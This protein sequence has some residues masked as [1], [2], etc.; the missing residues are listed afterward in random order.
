MKYAIATNGQMVILTEDDKV[1]HLPEASI[2]ASLI[3]NPDD[4]VHIP[5]NKDPESSPHPPEP[6]AEFDLIVRSGDSIQDAIDA[7]KPGQVIGI[8]NGTFGRFRVDDGTKIKAL[9]G[10]APVVSSKTPITGWKNE[11]GLYWSAEIRI[12]GS[13]QHAA[14]QAPEED[15]RNAMRPEFVTF[16]GAPLQQVYRRADVTDK[17]FFVEGNPGDSLRLYVYCSKPDELDQF[18][19]ASSPWLMK[20]A[21]GDTKDV[22]VEG[23]AFEY[24]SNTGKQGMIESGGSGWVLRSLIGRLCNSIAFELTG[25]DQTFDALNGWTSGQMGIWG[26]GLRD[27]RLFNIVN[28]RNGWK[29]GFHPGWELSC[30]FQ[31]CERLTFRN[32][33]GKD[34]EGPGFWADISNKEFTGTGFDLVGNRGSGMKLEHVFREGDLSSVNIKD[35]RPDRRNGLVAGLQMQSGIWDNSIKDVNIE[36][37]DV[38][39]LYKILEPGTYKRDASGR[40]YFEKITIGESVKSPY[41]IEGTYEQAGHADRFV[42][43]DPMPSLVKP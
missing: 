20:P 40:N 33:I 1:I 16:K 39:V 18:H 32:W 12:P 11:F 38:G 34:N 42:S 15:H 29:E 30:K 31:N 6:D 3:V 37:V 5:D 35:T 43:C 10:A 26:R 41:R 2:V 17:T 22:H 21:A 24:A 36:G 8:D 9:P 13:Y 19:F 27:S 7:A 28:A 25:V 4:V 23:L 14:K